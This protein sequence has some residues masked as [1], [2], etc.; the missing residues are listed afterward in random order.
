MHEIWRRRNYFIDFFVDFEQVLFKNRF[1][2][3][4]SNS[5]IKT[6]EQLSR[7]FGIAFI[8]DFEQVFSLED[9]N[10]MHLF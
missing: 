2:N 4:Y 9:L 10:S 8:V 5:T 1:V 3:T 6:A 7:L